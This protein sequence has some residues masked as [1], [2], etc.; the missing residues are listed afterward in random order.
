MTHQ[1]P[2][3]EELKQIIEHLNGQLELDEHVVERRKYE[4]QKCKDHVQE[5]KD[6]IQEAEQ[7]TKACKQTLQNCEEDLRTSKK[8]LY[9]VEGLYGNQADKEK[10]EQLVEDAK[11]NV[12]IAKEDYQEMQS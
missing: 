2:T 9:D 11:A 1:L 4:L 8:L 6:I 7:H 10:V 12:Q 3:R 5:Y